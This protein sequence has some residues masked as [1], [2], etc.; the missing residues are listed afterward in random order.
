MNI[1]LIAGVLLHILLLGIVPLG[2]ILSLSFHCVMFPINCVMYVFNFIINLIL[3]HKLITLML[4]VIAAIAVVI[5]QLII[6]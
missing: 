1:I 6:V 4:V 5:D 3:S 2:S